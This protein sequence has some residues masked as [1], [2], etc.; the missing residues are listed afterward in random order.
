VESFEQSYP[1]FPGLNLTFEVRE[2]IIKHSRDY[3]ADEFPELAE[4]RLDLRP[5]L[6]AQIIDL[7]DEIAYNVADLD[8]GFEA[9]LLDL[10]MLRAEVP[11]FAES[12]AAV[13]RQFP[14][15]RTQPKFSD[16]IKRILDRLTTD[17]IETTL[18]RLHELSVRSVEDVR[19]APQRIVRFSADQAEVSASLK[20]FL[21]GRLYNHPAI[22]EERDRSVEALEQLFGFYLA[23]REA[24]PEYFAQQ[25]AQEP[26][27]RVVCDY[28]AGMT[29][30][31]LLRQHRGVFG[32]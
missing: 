19:R 9:R 7:V 24:M 16:A 18:S 21:V 31:F 25:A 30:H 1:G 14:S 28:I 12:Y 27:E 26:R 11:V 3:S 4:Y 32:S 15:A 10:D 23:H 5:P 17:L 8:D 20:R 2:G 22:V 29:D 13:E 6:E